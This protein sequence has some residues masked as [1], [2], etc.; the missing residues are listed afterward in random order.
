MQR[1]IETMALF[2]DI[3]KDSIISLIDPSIRGQIICK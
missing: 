1:N 3:F 2:L